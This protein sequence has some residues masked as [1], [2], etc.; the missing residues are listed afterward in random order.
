MLKRAGDLSFVIGIFFTIVSLIL[1]GNL[2]VKGEA[3]KL[4]LYSAAVFLV[5]GLAMMFLP[6]KTG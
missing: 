3:D 1:F 6:K 5:F 4:S 2:L